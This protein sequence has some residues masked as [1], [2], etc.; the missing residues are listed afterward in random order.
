ML[1]GCSVLWSALGAC[2]A[3]V[4]WR[5]A[6]SSVPPLQAYLFKYDSTHGQFH[7]EVSV[8]GGELLVNGST[9]KVFAW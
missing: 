3:H 4:P 1:L 7:G 9:I 8:K 6:L 2:G 5:C